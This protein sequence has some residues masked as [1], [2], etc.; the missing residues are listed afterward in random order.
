MRTSAGFVARFR[1]KGVLR[2]LLCA[3]LFGYLLLPF[4]V[5]HEQLSPLGSS[6]VA[7]DS[8]AGPLVSAWTTSACG[9]EAQRRS[10]GWVIV[11]VAVLAW[12]GL[13]ASRGRRT[14][15]RWRLGTAGVAVVLAATAFVLLPFSVFPDGEPAPIRCG[16]APVSVLLYMNVDGGQFNCAVRGEDRLLWATSAA[17]IAGIVLLLVAGAVR[18]GRRREGSA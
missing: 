5:V 10:L 6:S 11:T 18:R 7:T 15:G 14:P 2:G 17:G 12:W 4:S 9:D 8:C 16:P 13:A 1:G 3:G